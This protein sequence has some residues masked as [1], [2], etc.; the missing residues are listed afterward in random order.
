[1]SLCPC[2]GIRLWTAALLLSIAFACVRYHDILSKGQG[3][4]RSQVAV[5]EGKPEGRADSF[6][7]LQT[8]PGEKIGVK[9][10]PSLS[11]VHTTAQVRADVLEEGQQQSGNLTLAS[12]HGAEQGQE[13]LLSRGAESPTVCL[14]VIAKTSAA[15]E[16]LLRVKHLSAQHDNIFSRRYLVVDSQGEKVD[17][18]IARVADSLVRE[19]YLDEWLAVNYSEAYKQLVN[20]TAAWGN[21]FRVEAEEK[22]MGHGSLDNDLPVKELDHYFAIDQCS[23]EYVAI[24]E[25][26]MIASRQ[27]GYSWISEGIQ[28]LKDNRDLML[29]IPA[30]PG[31]SER[32]VRPRLTTKAIVKSSPPGRFV[33]RVPLVD[34]TCEHP[35]SLPGHASL[36]NLRRYKELVSFGHSLEHR[37]GGMLVHGKPCKKMAYVR[38]C[39]G[40]R[41]WA[42]AFEC[43]ICNSPNLKQAH[44]AEEHRGWLWYAPMT[45]MRYDMGGLRSEIS[46]AEL[47][48]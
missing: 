42:A 41:S 4:D 32:K 33:G 38:K 35:F 36:L 43:V 29:V 44:L 6:D 8:M 31:L 9:D 11:L 27:T 1:M 16:L 26:D 22:A 25:S 15:T 47:Q 12:P 20:L 24:L 7:I 3:Q 17:A 46:K 13:E 30:F 39:G 28:A 2:R 10:D 19:K 40:I 23:A 5:V 18:S 37:C 34:T 45:R 21:S 14:A 48:Q